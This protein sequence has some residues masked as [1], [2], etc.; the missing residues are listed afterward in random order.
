MISA[1]QISVGQLGFFLAAFW[2]KKRLL[3]VAPHTHEMESDE[4]WISPVNFVSYSMGKDI[5][6]IVGQNYGEI[7]LSFGCFLIGNLQ[8]KFVNISS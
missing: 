2:P 8:A 5:C 6:K 1:C 4:F 3:V 7:L